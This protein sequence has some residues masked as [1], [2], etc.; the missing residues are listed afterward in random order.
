MQ[1]HAHAHPSGLASKNNGRELL[2][3]IDDDDYDEDD[4]DAL[5]IIVGRPA[6]LPARPHILDLTKERVHAQPINWEKKQ[7]Q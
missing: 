5:A 6:C 3:I 1:T 7:A 2:Q 4:D